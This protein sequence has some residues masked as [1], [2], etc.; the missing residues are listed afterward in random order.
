MAS[1]SYEPSRNRWRIQFLGMDGKRRTVNIPT[2]RARDKGQSKAAAL[3]NHIEEL[4]IAVKSGT[5]PDPRVQQWLAGVPEGMH[6]KLLAAGLVPQV[7]VVSPPERKSSW[8]SAK[9]PSFPSM[10]LAV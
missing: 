5:T 6:A 8:F 9:Q 4:V 2:T 7:V 3:K 10:C 1:L